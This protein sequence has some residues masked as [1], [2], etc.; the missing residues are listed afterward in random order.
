MTMAVD[1]HLAPAPNYD[2]GEVHPRGLRSLV[3]FG[4]D[5]GRFVRLAEKQGTR[6]VDV[7]ER[8][9][10]AFEDSNE[11]ARRVADAAERIAD[12]ADGYLGWDDE[13][14]ADSDDHVCRGCGGV[15]APPDC[16]DDT[17]GDTTP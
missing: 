8:Y 2:D 4:R 16:G 1:E 10:V 7:F 14:D 3:R 15:H 11:Q 13:D 5:I 17:D 6:L 12:H 9:V